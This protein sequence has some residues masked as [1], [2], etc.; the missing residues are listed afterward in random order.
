MDT[1]KD[2]SFAYA[3]ADVNALALTRMPTTASE[4]L[5]VV[6]AAVP[7]RQR[8][9]TA[10]VLLVFGWYDALLLHYPTLCAARLDP[11]RLAWL[12]GCAT[13]N[14]ALLEFLLQQQ[15]YTPNTHLLLYSIETLFRRG[16]R[17]LGTHHHYHDT[18]MCVD[19]LELVLRLLP[20]GQPRPAFS[21][22]AWRQRGVPAADIGR[23]CRALAMN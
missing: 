22:S 14:C 16:R 20:P 8:E 1:V 18:I 10:D 11:L 23:V 2:A 4:Q 13:N 7:N 15:H 17:S 19:A 12:D 3:V 21:H 5:D 6:R 9:Y